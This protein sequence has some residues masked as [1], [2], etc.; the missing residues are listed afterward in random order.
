MKVK[1]D[2]KT[3][4]IIMKLLGLTCGRTMG[5]TEVLMKEALM[6]AEEQ[7]AEV[8]LIRMLDLD[9]RYCRQCKVHLCMQKGMDYCP[10]KDDALFLSNKILDSDALIIGTPIYS[11]MAPGQLFVI[12]DRLLGPKVDK[13]FAIEAKK[14]TGRMGQGKFDERLF[15]PRVAGLIADGGAHTTYQLAIPPLY[16]LTFGMQ[17]VVVDKLL[18]FDLTSTPGAV[19]LEDKVLM[20]TRKL[21][22]NVAAAMGQEYDEVEYKGDDPGTC[23]VCHNNMLLVGKTDI[24]ECAVCNIF[25]KIKVEGGK[26]SVSFPK[27]EQ[28]VSRLGF[29]GKRRHG[30]EIMEVVQKLAPRFGEIPGKIEK[31]RAYNSCLV[32]PPRKKKDAAE[33]EE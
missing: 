16:T 20:R 3:E 2:Q 22:Q 5:N 9:I 17:M 18:I 26:V 24:V 11:W 19:V 14:G 10:I 13:A 25:G 12:R 6:G 8:E 33:A 1:N 29:E 32:K 27:K 21:G 7:G 31:Y 28:E 23:P 4:V 30:D 15:K